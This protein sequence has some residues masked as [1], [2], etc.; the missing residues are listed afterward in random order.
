MRN[1]PDDNLAYSVFIKLENNNGSGFLLNADNKLILIS[2]KHVFFNDRNTLRGNK[3]EIECQTKDI[4]D[5]TTE[6]LLIDFSLV[7]ILIHKESDI[8]AIQLA[9]L[10]ENEEENSYKVQYIKGVS[11]SRVGETGIVCVNA[12]STTKTIKNV[13][14][15]NDVYLYGYPTS[16]GL[17]ELPQF[18]V[19]KPL[20][21]RGIVANIYESKGTI[22]LDCP[23]FPGNS[24]GPVVEVES[25]GL[26]SFHK[27]IGVVIQFIPYFQEWENKSSGLVNV[28]LMNSGYSVAVSMDKVFEIID[29][30]LDK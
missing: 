1:I 11:Q 22:I 16:L 10:K 13:L 7:E 2:A 8:V 18:D 12:K 27:I 28:Q 30:D 25:E 15:G 4:S 17:K 14:T 26:Q 5:A 23:V 20:L 6:K 29:F 19:S 9:N 21:R 24:G 3:A